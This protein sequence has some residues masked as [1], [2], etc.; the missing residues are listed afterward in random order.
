V[1]LADIEHLLNTTP[2]SLVILPAGKQSLA[3]LKADPRVHRL[4]RQVVA[5]RGQIVTSSEGL[6]VTRAADVWAGESGEVNDGQ[7]TPVILRDPQQSS[8]ALA[9][10]LIRRLK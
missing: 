9:Q 6:Q 4:L 8:E 7:K 5:Q 1:T 10:E 2:I 3:R